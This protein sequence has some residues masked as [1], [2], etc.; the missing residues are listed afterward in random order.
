MESVFQSTK[1]YKVIKMAFRKF[2]GL[3]YNKT[4]NYVS[5]NTTNNMKLNISDHIGKLNTKIVVDSHLDLNN[6]SMFNVGNIY[7]SNGADLQSLADNLDLLSNNNIWTGLNTFTKSTNFKDITCSTAAISVATITSIVASSIVSED[8]TSTTGK[9]NTISSKQ[10]SL[11]CGSNIDL[12]KND[13]TNIKSLTSADDAN[14]AGATGQVITANGTGGWSWQDGGT[15]GVT[16]IIGSTGIDVTPS[17]GVVTI[18]TTLLETSNTWDNTNTFSLQTTF[19]NINMN[20]T[21][22]TNIKSLTSADDANNAGATGQVITANGTGGWSWQDGGT[23]GVTSII[24]STGIDVTPSTGVVTISTTL[25]ETSNTWDNTNTFSLQTTFNNI[26]MNDTD[27]TNIKSL[28][29]ADDA[30]NAGATGQV[31]TANGTGGWSWENGGG[32]GTGVLGITGGANII[33]SD[34]AG[35]YTV[36]A[37]GLAIL[38]TTNEQTFT[39]SLVFGN[40]FT[41]DICTFNNLVYINRLG[42]GFDIDSANGK[43]GCEFHFNKQINGETDLL[44]YG[45]GEAGG[46]SIYSVGNTDP[47]NLVANFFPVEST[48]CGRLTLNTGGTGGYLS[49][50]GVTLSCKEPDVLAVGNSGNTDGGTLTCAKVSFSGT[51]DNNV[52]LNTNPDY[53]SLVV[54]CTAV[55]TG[56]VISCA[57]GIA[58]ITCPDTDTI[59]V[60]NLMCEKVIINNVIQTPISSIIVNP[61]SFY[62]GANTAPTTSAT[63]LTNYGYSGW[64][65]LTSSDVITWAFPVRKN[66]TVADLKGISVHFFNVASTFEITVYT[67]TGSKSYTLPTL[68][69]NTPYQGVAILA[70]NQVPN[71]ETTVA[72]QASTPIGTFLQTD[73]ITNAVIETTTSNEFVISKL[74]FHYTDVVISNLLN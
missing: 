41:A 28:T 29:S 36:G 72:M 61:S 24:G 45:Q 12:S 20:D 70:T 1:K 44:T 49:N 47:L 68:T 35:N 25:L 11:V 33:V 16:S 48:I 14:N 38:N 67:A 37:T 8:L 59:E 26:N 71:N 32:G 31:I 15:D 58:S 62:Y 22:I 73:L 4:N 43:L 19:N 52:Y 50:T 40:A 30:N 42:D 23:D 39:G 2:G 64:Y 55:N 17:T 10:G 27:I 9:F 63:I 60:G 53:D 7:F 21:D 13:I 54:N 34:T 46:L 51:S 3:E 56:I 65:Y 6:Q 18:S 57:T 66:A 5:A 69:T 74:N